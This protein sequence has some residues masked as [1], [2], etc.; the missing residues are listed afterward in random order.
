VRKQNTSFEKLVKNEGG[1]MALSDLDVKQGYQGNGATVSFPIPFD[2]EDEDEIV[3]Y[4]RDETD[5]DAITETILVLTTNYTLTG[6]PATAV[7]MNVAP[8]A[9]QFVFVVRDVDLIQSSAFSPGGLQARLVEAAFDRIVRQVQQVN[10]KVERA[11][12]L[13][14]TSDND[15]LEMD[16]PTA[17]CV[18]IYSDDATRVGPG[19]TVAE[20]EEW[21]DD[22]EAAAAA[23]QNSENNAQASADGAANSATAASTSAAQA[24]TSATNSAN[25]ASASAASA[26]AA[27][28][29]AGAA[30]TS[31]AA[32]L[33][34]ENAA[35]DYVD[36]AIG[37]AAD[38]AAALAASQAAEAAAAA[39][40]TAAEAAQAA[41]EDARDDAETAAAAAI[42]ASSTPVVTG[43]RAAANA[44]TAA[45]G[46]AFVGGAWFNTWYIKG[47]GGAPIN[48]TKNPQVDA[49]GTL[50]QRLRLVG[51]DDAAPVTFEDGTGLLLNGMWIGEN[52]KVLDLEW[53][54][55][56][57]LETGRR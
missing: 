36:D 24:A 55:S 11:L 8:T 33:A 22:A 25:S 9:T 45:G 6:S 3:V 34:S 35:A 13:A 48:I 44:I 15:P 30:A 29:S 41:A 46:V 28:V 23:A 31:A 47:N 21:K 54:G 5:P 19:P 10:E 43:T 20:L 27:A 40:V 18:L 51:T 12:K 42:A 32:A 14:M 2:Y 39:A 53:D 52:N 49:A 56:N 4:F 1:K 37:A 7:H 38:A 50:G 16:D 26:S 57:W 17:S